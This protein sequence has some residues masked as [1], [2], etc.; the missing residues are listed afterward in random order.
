MRIMRPTLPAAVLLIAISTLAG[1]ASGMQTKRNKDFRE[2]IVRGERPEITAC[3]VAAI[4][5]AR[6]SALFSNIRWNID[7]SDQAILRESES[8]G[9]L[10]RNIQLSVRMQDRAP[11]FVLGEK[12]QPV[13]VSCEQQDDGI[14]HID[15]KPDGS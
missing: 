7:D 2:L 10:T 8:N 9:R 15:V 4:D 13:N 1:S 11:G 12:W 14:V 3:L 6:H 5:Y